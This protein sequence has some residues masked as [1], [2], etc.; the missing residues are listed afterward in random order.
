MYMY[1]G[2]L[3]QYTKV[4][5]GHSGEMNGVRYFT[6]EDGYGLFLPVSR[7]QRDDRFDDPPSLIRAPTPEGDEA[8][9]D[10]KKLSTPPPLSVES[11]TL[12]DEDVSASQS[13]ASPPSSG[14]Y[15]SGGMFL[16]GT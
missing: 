13:T 8:E 7:L 1:D 5:G 6:C 3:L 11:L 14:K 9:K 4:D 15:R 16:V 12:T 10:K 2:V